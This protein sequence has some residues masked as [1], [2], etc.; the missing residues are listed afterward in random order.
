MQKFTFKLKD[1]F[2]KAFANYQSK[3][4]EL[5]DLIKIQP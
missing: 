4:H 2:T 5:E 1:K 3:V